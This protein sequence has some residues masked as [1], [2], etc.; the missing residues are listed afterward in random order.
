M[1]KCLYINNKPYKSK[2]K[3]KVK[4]NKYRVVKRFKEPFKRDSLKT[5]LTTV[6]LTGTHVDITDLDI[7]NIAKKVLDIK[8]VV[9]YECLILQNKKNNKYMIQINYTD[10]QYQNLKVNE[11]DNVYWNS[12][13]NKRIKSYRYNS[14]LK[15]HIKLNVGDEIPNTYTY[16]RVINNN[17]LSTLV[18]QTKAITKMINSHL[19]EDTYLDCYTWKQQGFKIKVKFKDKWGF[20]D[21]MKQLANEY[22]LKHNRKLSAKIKNK[23]SNINNLVHISLSDINDKNGFWRYSNLRFKLIETERKIN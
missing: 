17:D 21:K 15:H 16:V 7:I 11:G 13:T 22:A 14:K 4:Y 18:T 20:I 2:N 8:K 12:K 9:H 23:Y 10:K 19:N 6:S 5:T 3:L 1:L